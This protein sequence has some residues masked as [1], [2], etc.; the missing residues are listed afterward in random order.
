MTT[1]LRILIV[2]DSEDDAALLLRELRHSGYDP[3]FE[4]V[5][6]PAAMKDA[7]NKGPWDVVV[8]DHAMP[9]FNALAALKML[10]E[11]RLDVPFLIL[12]GSIGEET[13][14]AAM[15]AGAH[16]YVMKGDR[17][18]LVPAIQREV[19]EA[20]GRR[21]R[22]RAE[23][24]RDRFFTL[25]LDMICIAGFNGYF[26]QLNPA[27]EKTLGFTIQELK[28]KPFIEFVHPE[29][30]EATIAEAKKIMAGVDTISF[31]NRYRCKDGSYKWLLWSVTAVLEEQLFY[32]VARDITERKRAEEERLWL[33]RLKQYLSP[34][35]V[36]SVI[37]RED[38]LLGNTRK[39]LT[40]VFADLSGFT[41]FSDKADPEDVVNLLNDYLSEMIAL[42]FKYEGTLDK[43]MGDGML[44]FFGDPVPMQ[45]HAERA[46]KM[47]IE[48]EEKIRLLQKKW[49]LEEYQI[50]I[51][52]GINTGY[53]TVGNIGSENRMDYTVIGKQVNLASRLQSEAKAGQI[54]ISKRTFEAVKDLI[55]AGDIQQIT[56]KGLQGPISVY[57]IIG[58]KKEKVLGD[59][60]SRLSR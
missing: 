46:V 40:V 9:H 52:I 35:V 1:P 23:E 60:D 45:D 6:T 37:S 26:I 14:V 50:N 33:S 24:Q 20:E 3:M 4:R 44:V 8:S 11:S 43:I 58:L 55:E 16:D 42:V 13:A 31:E 34:Q 15:K 29:D 2:E 27:W 59:V 38:I 36:R 18:R 17:P 57:S 5:D 49:L 51:G 56:V 32:A 19:R 25:S 7:L 48:M 10:Q 47:A 28:A 54:L 39:F 22:R 12:S 30:Q 21:E 41:E 53:V